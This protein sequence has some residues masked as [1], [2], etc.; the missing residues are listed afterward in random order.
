MSG[1]DKESF[2]FEGE[3]AGAGYAPPLLD[4]IAAGFLVALSV[5]VMIASLRLP[6]PGDLRTAPGLLPFLTAAS[7]C[8]MAL[9]L[10]YAALRRR[11]AGATAAA[12]PRDLG[13]DLRTLGLVA[14]LVVY[15]GCLD[16]LPFSHGFSIGGVYFTL[17][18][19]EP[20][21]I[22]ALAAI[23]HAFWRGPLWITTAV[24]AGWTLT[25]SVVFQKV[26][27]IPLPGGF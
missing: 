24:S 4:L 18:T 14:A 27:V 3:E 16:L 10:G 6:V 17:T 26:F 25:L 21:T 12:G 23:I 13:T 2:R 5:A 11:R 7:L 20:A 19:F 15:V 8:G 1:E 22:V 9:F